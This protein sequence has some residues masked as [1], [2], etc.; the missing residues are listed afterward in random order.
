MGRSPINALMKKLVGFLDNYI[1]IKIMD[2][3]KINRIKDKRPCVA[4]S[5]REGIG[6]G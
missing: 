5:C 1:N 3:K 4:K 6:F 2:Q